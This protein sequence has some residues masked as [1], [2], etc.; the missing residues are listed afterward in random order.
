M[1]NYEKIFEMLIEAIIEDA[2]NG[3]V[4]IDMDEVEKAEAMYEP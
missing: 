4:Q 1:N 3:G 2:M